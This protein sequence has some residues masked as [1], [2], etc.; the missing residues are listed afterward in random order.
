MS[1]NMTPQIFFDIVSELSKLC[2]DLEYDVFIAGGSVRNILLNKP[3]S[4]LDLVVDSDKGAGKLALL[5]KNIFPE[6]TEPVAFNAN[7]NF[8]LTVDD[9]PVN[10]SDVKEIN[11]TDFTSV[12]AP[13]SNR[14]KADALQRDFTVNTMLLHVSDPNP[15]NIID[16]LMIGKSDLNNRGISHP[17]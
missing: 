17:S 11:D 13:V 3:V 1:D 4:D 9:Y 15:A 14:M 5:L 6:A 8:K 16:P 10:I 12:Y 2:R 7:T